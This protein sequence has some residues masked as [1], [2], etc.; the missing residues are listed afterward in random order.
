M[1]F[2]GGEVRLAPLLRLARLAV[3][4]SE[5]ARRCIVPPVI[6]KFA[7][8]RIYRVDDA[9]LRLVRLADNEKPNRLI[10]VVEEAVCN[11]GPGREA[12]SITRGEPEELAID[13]DIG[14]SLDHIDE[15]LFRAF[16][17][18]KGGPTTWR[19][20]LMVNAEF[21]QAKRLREGRTDTPPLIRAAE[22]DR[23]VILDLLVVSD[24]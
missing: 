9:V 21:R 4:W 18:R 20:E 12:N 11:P 23:V 10:G 24:E 1:C 14:S 15:L 16:G 17:V 19:Q 7:K 2:D 6:A 8:L 13:P 3:M 22:Q 5:L